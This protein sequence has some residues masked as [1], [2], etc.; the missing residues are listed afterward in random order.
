MQQQEE[1]VTFACTHVRI[2][3]GLVS[4]LRTAVDVAAEIQAAKRARSL[5]ASQGSGRLSQ[6]L[7]AMDL[8]GARA[9]ALTSSRKSRIHSVKKAL[10]QR[11]Q[12]MM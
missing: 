5:A 8:D 12:G 2:F 1:S 6:S 11:L 4:S 3:A 10:Y 7:S 9:A